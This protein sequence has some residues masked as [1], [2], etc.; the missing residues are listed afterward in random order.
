[1]I[2][3][4]LTLIFNHDRSAALNRRQRRL[5]AAEQK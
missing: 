3:G 2:N 5:A 4:G 1:M